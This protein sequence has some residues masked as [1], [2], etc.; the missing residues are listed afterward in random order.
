[1]NARNAVLAL[2]LV[3]GAARGSELPTVTAEDAAIMRTVLNGQ[4][5]SHDEP[6]FVIE[7]TASPDGTEHGVASLRGA[8]LGPN[9]TLVTREPLVEDVFRHTRRHDAIVVDFFPPR[10]TK[11][12]RVA[13]IACNVTVYVSG[14]ILTRQWTTT[15]A[16]GK[17]DQWAVRHQ[18]SSVVRSNKDTS[19][20]E[21]PLR[22]GGDVKA[23]VLIDRVEPK[24]TPEADA[25][26][27]SGIVILEAVIDRTGHVTSAN[28]LKPLPFGLDKAAVD[29]VKQWTFRPGTLNGEPVTVLFNLVVNFRM[30]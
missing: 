28:V 27:I 17:D 8:D 30:E 29:A 3:A 18:L 4:F 16:H 13:E 7:T 20:D 5:P 19:E 12:H 25:A 10:V 15:L 23:P 24:R 1:M 11:D 21:I 9:V 26:R 2:C 14:T 22:V 6:L